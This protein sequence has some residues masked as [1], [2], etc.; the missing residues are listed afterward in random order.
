MADQTP[1]RR[2]RHR[3]PSTDDDDVPQVISPPPQQA[4]Q[5]PFVPPVQQPSSEM[6]GVIEIL[7][8]LTDRQAPSASVTWGDLPTLDLSKEGEVDAWFLAFENK[9]RASG[10]PE[11]QWHTKLEA[12]P[13]FPQEL[14]S[15]FTPL[16]LGAYPLMRQRVLQTHG[17]IVP[18]PYY[19]HRIHHV[20]GEYREPIR[21]QLDT[22]LE[23][24]N[25]A[26]R[27]ANVPP[28]GELDLSYAFVYAFPP[29]VA[30]R[31]A[32]QLAMARLSPEP[33]EV[34]YRL[35][36]SENEATQNAVF[37]AVSQAQVPEASLDE[38][39]EGP[40]LAAV[41]RTRRGKRAAPTLESALAPA[42]AAV[43]KSLS[44]LAPRPVKR[45]R[46]HCRNC[47]GSCTSRD[48]CP[49]QGRECHRCHKMNHYA[50]VCQSAPASDPNQVNAPAVRPQ[51]NRPFRFGP[52]PQP[53]R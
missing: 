13:R 24:H 23:L 45:P 9:M 51:P 20:R 11:R 44:A 14:K 10:V 39:M 26:A 31:L 40:V 6:S 53:G 32:P 49:A 34:L 22:L 29:A 8:L 47:G 4:P 42:L 17:P 3:S 1:S 52:R 35:A 18:L 19:R 25:R 16:E 15:K 48:Q 43:A 28:Y 27:D 41:S 33:L 2:L 30:A 21:R 38:D 36:P 46:G 7:R 5:P 50:S 12:C 37:A